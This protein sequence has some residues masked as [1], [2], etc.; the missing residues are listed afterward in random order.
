MKKSIQILFASLTILFSFQLTQ[1]QTCDVGILPQQLD[2]DS[3]IFTLQAN[4]VGTAPYSFEWTTD[5]PAAVATAQRND[6]LF[7]ANFTTPGSYEVCVVVTDALGESCSDCRIV[8]AEAAPCYYPG[9]IQ[10]N[11]LETDVTLLTWDPVPDNQKFQVQYRKKE[12][13]VWGEW[14]KKSVSAN[15]VR[16]GN[17]DFGGVYQYRVR[18]FCASNDWSGFSLSGQFIQRTCG[19]V[20][21]NSIQLSFNS[22]KWLLN[23]DGVESG[24]TYTIQYRDNG[25]S[26]WKKTVATSNA[27][28]FPETYFVNGQSYDFRISAICTDETA[29]AYSIVNVVTANSS[30][31]LPQERL[32]GNQLTSTSSIFPNPAKDV[33]N[34][35]FDGEGTPDRFVISDMTGRSVKEGNIAAARGTSQSTLDIADLQTGYYVIRFMNNGELVSTEKFVKTGNK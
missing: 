7:K 17:L 26:N 6:A 22:G 30:L 3:Y 15:K 10:A 34:V 14:M 4:E 20:D 27:T 11:V 16:L 13:G 8:T 29:G 2:H 24:V 1:A 35:A 28:S 5:G 31:A 25:T 21:G 33:L 19:Q 32:A 9:N 23:W 18:T 12:S